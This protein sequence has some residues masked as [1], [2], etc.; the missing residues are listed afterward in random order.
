MNRAVGCTIMLLASCS[1]LSAQLAG[2]S[3]S[4]LTFAGC[5]SE[6]P[7][8]NAA[9]DQVT[10]Q[11]NC[12]LIP[13]SNTGGNAQIFLINA[14]GTGIVQLTYGSL[15]SN[16]PSF[17]ASGNKVTFTSFSDLVP[18][19][20]TDDNSEIFVINSDGT[21]LTQLT[22]SVGGSFVGAG[23][24]ANYLPTLEYSGRQIVFVSTLPLVA[25]GDTDG[26]AEVFAI[27]SDGTGL[28]E[29]T[30]TPAGGSSSSPSTDPS[31]K[32]LFFLSNAD[33]VGA[34]SNNLQ[35]LFRMNANATG[36]VQLTN[37]PGSGLSGGFNEKTSVS[38]DGTKVVF[39]SNADLVSGN[40]TDGNTEIF[41]LDTASGTFT[42]ITNTN[43]GRGCWAPSISAS[44]KTVVF[45]CDR[46]LVGSNPGQ[47]PEL[48][49]AKLP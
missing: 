26:S 12:D 17:D 24:L 41:M 2:V 11:S 37:V 32:H 47:N 8:I 40:N 49:L 31:G 22:H 33:W 39:T 36:V 1:M 10:F 13:G 38:A 3:Y 46:D 35:Q 19:Q 45:G 6:Y 25:N 14:N 20:N 18:G 34:N 15:P 44:G 23:N 48:F 4:Q 21:G 16:N 5:D 29:L 30:N 27:R 42:Q 28:V 43:G 9:A 7:S